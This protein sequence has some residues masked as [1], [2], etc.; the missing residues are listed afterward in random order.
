MI[1]SGYVFRWLV[2]ASGLCLEAVLAGPIVI[3]SG[4][5]LA[6][7]TQSNNQ[8]GAN[9]LI[10]PHPSSVW[11][12]PSMGGRWISHVLSGAG[13]TVVAGGTIDNAG[14]ITTPPTAIFYQDLD[15]DGPSIS[16]SLNVWADDTAQVFI[17]GVLVYATTSPIVEG[18]HCVDAGIGCRSN[19]G[20]II[21]LTGLAEGSHTIEFRV[22][23]LWGDSF[24]LLYEDGLE[25]EVTIEDMPEPSSL[26]LVALGGGLMALRF[27]RRRP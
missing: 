1:R 14:L 25:T 21:P 17:D 23:Q 27:L 10:N 15:L 13:Q 22:Y 18:V 26:C 11:A 7:W 5:D 4:T 16:G 2:L 3:L 9:V 24:G 12:T 20:G 19:M 8:T 6:G